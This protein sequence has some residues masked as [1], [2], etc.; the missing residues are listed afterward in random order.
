MGG[1]VSINH[2]SSNRIELSRL[3]QD[4]LF[5]ETPPPMGGCA[6]EWLVQWVNGWG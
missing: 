3:R 4:L 6:G 1:G 5:I 2:K